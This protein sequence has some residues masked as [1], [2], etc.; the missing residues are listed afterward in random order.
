MANKHDSVPKGGANPH[1]SPSAETPQNLL[2][3]SSGRP[4]YIDLEIGCRIYVDQKTYNAYVRPRESEERK[5][6]RRERCVIAGKRCNGDCSQCE[7]PR[8]GRP[9]SLEEQ[10]EKYELEYAD[11][12]V[13]IVEDLAHQELIE[14]LL[15]EVSALPEEQKRIAFLI[16]EGHS[17]HA[18]ARELGI[19]QR[20]AYDRIK[21]VLSALREKLEPFR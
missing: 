3:P 16:S 13:D 17:T 5:E 6:R 8:T 7:F 9:I 15:R 19:P 1:K 11:R 21:S 2:E 4:F 10:F 14:A 20:T 12:S 18:I